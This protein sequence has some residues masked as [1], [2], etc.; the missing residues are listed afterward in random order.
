MASEERY[1]TE[2]EPHMVPRIFP[3]NLTFQIST[4]DGWWLTK[5]SS[6]RRPGLVEVVHDFMD[7]RIRL[8]KE[9]QYLFSSANSE[10]GI[11]S[12]F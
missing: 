9:I 6:R 5:M 3:S 4:Y 12:L 8:N 11:D 2:T 1:I 7:Q 10:Y